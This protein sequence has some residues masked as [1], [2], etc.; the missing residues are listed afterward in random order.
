MKIQ[1]FILATFTALLLQAA[2]TTR[3]TEIRLIARA[4]DMGAAQAINEG[5]IEAY[6]AGIVRSVEVIVPGPWFLDAVRLLKE[7][8]EVDVGVHLTLTSEWDRVK[9]RPLTWVTS[10]VDAD[11]YFPP[12]TEALISNKINLAE[13][14]RELKAQ[15]EM[16]RRHL[17]AERITHLSAH[18]GAATATPQ[19]KAITEKLARQYKL[20]TDDSLKKAAPFGNRTQSSDLRE[21]ALVGLLETL[22]PGNWL[23]VEHPGYDTPE[24]RNLGHKGYENVASDRSNVRRAFTSEA[25]LK[26]VKR[27]GIKLISYRDL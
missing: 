12:T 1:I 8:P 11:G 7:H 4:D 6:K 9:W 17:G 23:I 15:I 19:L 24:L 5:C 20:R 16:A 10:F 26:V 27:R 25:A 3:P 22:E 18:M 21:R 2:P 13:V 14:E